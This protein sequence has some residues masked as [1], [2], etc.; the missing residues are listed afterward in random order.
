MVVFC[1]YANDK[2]NHTGCPDPCGRSAPHAC[3][4]RPA[5][6]REARS[7][8]VTDMPSV[9]RHRM[10]RVGADMISV[11]EYG[12]GPAVLLLHGIPGWRGSWEPVAQRL[13]AEFR[14]IVPDLLGFGESARPEGDIHAATQAQAL[15]RLLDALHV[16]DAHVVGFDFGGPVA[17][18]MYSREPHRFLSLTLMATNTFVDTPIPGPLKLA[19][20]PI[21]GRLA[22]RLFFGKP[23]L[24]LLWVAAVRARR[25][26][27]FGRHQAALASRRGVESTRWVFYES[28]RDLP[29][30]YA[31]VQRSLATVAVPTMVVWS[32]RDPF[33]PPEV[34]RRVCASLPH[35][36]LATVAGVG[37][38]L[39]EEAPEDVSL[40]L[41]R[42]LR[43]LSPA[44]LPA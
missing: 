43:S 18:S 15:L 9:A 2:S 17:L 1:N 23:G 31:D 21:I 16:R 32:D 35:A 28:L 41:R 29:G 8:F 24:L 40:H 11:D 12:A 36:S 14:V 44:G 25:Q 39:P 37:H 42:H 22:F 26:Y 4:G 19:R 38:F 30:R 3:R 27:T 10:V 34:G 13:A 20:V 6:S 5:A 33:F 7:R